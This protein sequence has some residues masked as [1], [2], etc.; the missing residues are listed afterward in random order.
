[1]AARLSHASSFIFY[2]RA[3]QA[4]RDQHSG[5]ASRLAW[6]TLFHWQRQRPGL[7]VARRLAGGLLVG[8][9]LRCSGLQ[10]SRELRPRSILHGRT[11]LLLG[12]LDEELPVH[13]V[14]Q[15]VACADDIHVEE[16][17]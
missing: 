12:D 13:H 6:S 2:S 3:P 17:L 8:R 14:G 1:H 7:L 11:S 15:D 5:T 16:I 4:R 9:R 10:L